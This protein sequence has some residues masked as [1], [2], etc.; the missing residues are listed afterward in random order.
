MS[1]KVRLAFLVTALVAVLAIVWVVSYEDSGRHCLYLDST[2][3]YVT[4]EGDGHLRFPALRTIYEESDGA[5]VII[6]KGLPTE[7][8]KDLV[9]LD[10]ISEING[11]Y[12]GGARWYDGE[13]LGLTSED[14]SWYDRLKAVSDFF[15][16]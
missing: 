16:E 1:A 13:R 15:T 11:I 10:G 4:L 12:G 2:S 3:Q 8:V 9:S 6:R 7:V 5:V 14:K